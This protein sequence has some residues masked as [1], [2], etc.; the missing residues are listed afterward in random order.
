MAL[1]PIFT[2]LCQ[3]Y[4]GDFGNFAGSTIIFF[5]ITALIIRLLG[6]IVV[7]PQY[8]WLLLLLRYLSSATVPDCIF[9]PLLAPLPHKFCCTVS[10]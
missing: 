8:T 7:L 1:N 3:F 10:Q 5:F 2:F 6:H 4:P 9:F